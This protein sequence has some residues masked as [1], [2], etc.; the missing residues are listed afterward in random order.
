MGIS[1]TRADE[2]RIVCVPQVPPKPA[3]ASPVKL[4]AVHSKPG[5]A[6]PDSPGAQQR[7]QQQGGEDAEQQQQQQRRA[8]LP[9]RHSAPPG[10]SPTRSRFTFSGPPHNNIAKPMQR[11]SYS[12]SK[13]EILKITEDN[14]KLCRCAFAVRASSGCCA[15]GVCAEMTRSSAPSS[16]P[17]RPPP[18]RAR[19][20]RKLLE[21]SS[22][23]TGAR[24]GV[25]AGGPPLHL[26]ESA[27]TVNRRR[28]EDRIA[29]ENLAIFKRLQAIKPSPEV[30][31]DKLQK[32]FATQTAY[33]HNVRKFKPLAPLGGSLIKAHHHAAGQQQA[34]GQHNL[35][36][37]HPGTYGEPAAV[38]AAVQPDDVAASG[39]DQGPPPAAAALPPPAAAVEESYADDTTPVQ[40]E[41]IAA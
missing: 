32:H 20:R 6:S 18:P 22:A 41:A 4:P 26:N 40:P 21:I 7:D 35:A 5:R 23:P 17:A 15:P 27:S 14:N 33:S 36:S 28:R 13:F 30:N 39:V 12:H 1:S 9:P 25:L 2:L 38:V 11:E 3:V 8:G 10:G 29:Q 34:A 16:N 31:R 37:T 24:G 19:S